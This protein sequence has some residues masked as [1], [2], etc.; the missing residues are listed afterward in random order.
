LDRTVLKKDVKWS[1]KLEIAYLQADYKKLINDINGE[2][3]SF[4]KFNP[5]IRFVFEECLR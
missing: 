1:N 3:D 5:T 2:Y 4:G